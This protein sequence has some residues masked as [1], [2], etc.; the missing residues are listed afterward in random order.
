MTVPNSL[1]PPARR[2]GSPAWTAVGAYGV[3]LG[4]GRSK[5]A[6]PTSW[7]DK[8]SC[9]GGGRCLWRACAGWQFPTARAHHLGGWG[10]LPRRG[11]SLWRACKG[12]QF[13][14]GPPAKGSRSPSGVAV[15]A[16]GGPARDCRAHHPGPTI[17]GAG[18]RAQVPVGA[19][20]GL[21]VAGSS[22]RPGPT[23]FGDGESCPCGGQCPWWASGGRQLPM[24]WAG[25]LGG[26]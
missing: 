24:A 25:R 16:Y 26:R 9:P 13:P 1:G 23:R 3:P 5:R 6:G 2:T 4:D 18:S 12:G 11:S 7:G 21:A 15:G 20:G 17:S 10:V 19:D 8:E 14:T 22:Q